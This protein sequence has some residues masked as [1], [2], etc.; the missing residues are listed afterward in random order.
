[1]WS[2]NLVSQSGML[3]Y[4]AN[5]YFCQLGDEQQYLKKL[6]SLLSSKS[7]WHSTAVLTVTPKQNLTS[8]PTKKC[9]VY[10]TPRKTLI[11]H[12]RILACFRFV[13]SHTFSFDQQYLWNNL[14]QI[15]KFT[16]Y[17]SWLHDESTNIIFTLSIIKKVWLRANLKRAYILGQGGRQSDLSSHYARMENGMCPYDLWF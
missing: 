4:D 15:E 7:N 5:A 14:F 10:W 16:C 3:L 6:A 9:G 17:D 13:L 2:M 1:M 8:K 11:L 12:P